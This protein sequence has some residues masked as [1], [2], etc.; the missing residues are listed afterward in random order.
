MIPLAKKLIP[1]LIVTTILIVVSVLLKDA[2]GDMERGLHAAQTRFRGESKVDSSVVI[3]YFN[4]D[5]VRALG[6]WPLKRSYYALVVSILHDLG[7]KAIG[8]DVTFSTENLQYPE[9]DVLLENVIR[10]ASPV[11]LGGYFR[12]IDSG[13]SSTPDSVAGRFAYSQ[14]SGGSFPEGSGFVSSFPRIRDAAAS[15]GHSSLTDDLA[16]PVFVRSAGGLVPCFAFELLR[17]AVG[18]QKSAVSFSSHAVIIHSAEG[19]LVVPL[20]DDGTFPINYAGGVSSLNTLPALALIQSYDAE[21]VGGQPAI[22]IQRIRGKIVLLGVIAEGRSTFVPTPFTGAFPSI[23]IHATVL[24]NILD[25]DYVTTLPTWL[26]FC[27]AF[28]MGLVATLCTTGKRDLQGLIIIQLVL[29]GYIALSFLA[30]SAFALSLPLARPVFVLMATAVVMMVIKHES[31]RRSLARIEREKQHATEQLEDKERHLRRLEE[32]LFSSGRERTGGGSTTLIEE[33]RKYKDEIRRLTEQVSDLQAY[34][35][36]TL[37]AGQHPMVFEGIVCRADS[38]MASVTELVK[39]IAPSDAAVLVLGESGTGKELVARA[40]HQQSNRREKP[41]VAVNC[42]ALSE[43]L[44]E[45]ELFGHEKGA[46]T[47]AVGEKPGRFELADG[48]TFFLDEIG[49]TSELFQVKLLR[50]LQEGEFERVGG[51]ATRKVNVRII[52]ATNR[53]LKKAVAEKK[54][55]EDVYYRLNVLNVQLPPLRDHA[56]DVPLLIDHFLKAEGTNIRFSTNVVEALSQYGWKGNVRELQ[57]VMKRALI[58][59]GSDNRDIVRMKDLPEEIAAEAKK[60]TDI[61]EQILNGLR[62]K[63]FSRSAISETA[64]ELGGLNRGTVAEYLRGYSFRVFADHR[65]DLEAT[66]RAIAQSQDAEVL[67][68]VRKKT[69]EYLSNAVEFVSRDRSLD[70]ILRDSRPKFKNLPQRYHRILEE[71]LNSYHQGRW[72][73]DEVGS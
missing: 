30:F 27:I 13:M 52:A 3:V 41:F 8:I 48:G 32:E 58:L 39:K 35:P 5:D 43:T 66:V 25:R 7:A 38:P 10:D 50:V 21:K 51:T 46:F 24:S 16:V 12:I 61:E 31:V 70:E 63:N 28:G 40:I 26:E 17:T 29:I 57:S 44:L 9:Y 1:G 73:L 65:N 49:E 62:E 18:A 72:N 68:R 54:F 20:T 22:P 64:D 15:C 71:I 33:I 47:G 6:G 2:F 14:S 36:T 37:D 69:L 34:Q 67:D 4:E 45:S 56:G 55:R 53:D 23:G 19:S 11:V 60:S 42:G 59:A